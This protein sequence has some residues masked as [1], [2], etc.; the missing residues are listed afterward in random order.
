M[1]AN[2]GLSG[3]GFTRVY[4]EE[5]IVIEFTT[6]AQ[7]GLHTFVP[8]FGRAVGNAPLQWTFPDAN[9]TLGTATHSGNLPAGFSFTN[10]GSK[11]VTVEAPDWDS[12]SI[13]NCSSCRLTGLRF[14][15]D[16]IGKSLQ[17]L[18]CQSN[19]LASLTLPSSMDALQ[20]LWCFTNQLTSLTLPTSMDALQQLQCQSNQL[21]SLTLP[22]SMD[23]LLQLWCFTNQLTSLTLPTSMDALQ[24]LHCQSNQLTSLTLPSSMDALLQLR[25]EANQLTSLTL[26]SSMDAL[27][28][29]WCFTNQLTSLTLPTSMDALQLLWCQS[30]QLNATQITNIFQRCVDIGKKIANLQVQANPGSAAGTAQQALLQTVPRAWT[31]TR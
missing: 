6:T 20:Q 13:L 12:F 9:N 15:S 10:A 19:Q 22:S 16:E 30:N 8:A 18:Q 7:T 21:T 4:G 2:T 24:Q 5:S 26:P 23:A 29:L 25:C 28:Q 11:I 14:L 1:H 3:L 31:I 17:Q 27:Q